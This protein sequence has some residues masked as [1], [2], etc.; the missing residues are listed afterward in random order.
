METFYLPTLDDLHLVEGL[1]VGVV[2]GAEALAG[3]PSL[4]TLQHTAQ[5]GF[6]G[7]NVHGSE[8]RNK[9]IVVHVDN[10]LE[11]VKPEK[12]AQDKIGKRTFVG[13]PFLQEGMVVAISDSLFKY[14]KTK[15]VPES[16]ELVISNPHT[17]QGMQLWKMKADRIE[18]TYS[19]RFGVITGPVD[20]L[21]H[22]RL[23]KGSFFLIIF[24][25]HSDP[26]IRFEPC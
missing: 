18:Q 23:L 9:S 24:P 4:N 22:V 21:L 14:E 11:N 1:C 10:N 25:A 19:K 8:S 7:V 15:I 16:K 20:V 12:I 2:L 13:W 6:H 26:S 5:V 3:F 17:P